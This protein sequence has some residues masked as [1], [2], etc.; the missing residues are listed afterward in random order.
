M[1]MRRRRE[2]E[3]E[4]A[5]PWRNSL[6]FGFFLATAPAVCADD[7]DLGGPLPSGLGWAVHVVLAVKVEAEDL[8]GLREAHVLRVA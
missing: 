5:E 1:M 6:S 3:R 2:R 8:E 4:A 7:G